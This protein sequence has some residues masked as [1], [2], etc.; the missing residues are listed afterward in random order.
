MS[1]GF[2]T[3][4]DSE[5][6]SAIRLR[7]CLRS[8]KHTLLPS[9]RELRGLCPRLT[10]Y[11]S[12]LPYK[13]RYRAWIEPDFRDADSE[14]D[15]ERDPKPASESIF[16]LPTPR[17]PRGL[18]QRPRYYRPSEVFLTVHDITDRPR[19]Y[20]PSEILRTVRDFSD[21]P[22][23]H[24]PSTILRTVRDIADRPRFSDLPRYHGSSKKLQTVH[25]IADRSRCYGNV[26]TLWA[27]EA[28]GMIDIS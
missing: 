3:Q 27:S 20:G 7:T 28:F 4:P 14:P 13:A 8:Y 17:K 24:G 23:Y 15:P 11:Q 5:L 16:L 18:R 10:P 2:R 19:Y 21:H 1:F 12:L 25:D 26:R 22:Q 6:Y 9:A